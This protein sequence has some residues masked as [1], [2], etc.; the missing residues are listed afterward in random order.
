[1]SLAILLAALA[2]ASLLAGVNAQAAAQIRYVAPGGTCGS[3]TLCYSTI[4]AA[5]DAAQ[6]GD[7]IRVAAGTYSG[8]N[9]QGGWKQ[10]VYIDKS[11][12]IRGGFTTSNWTT[13]NPEANVTE[14]NAMTLGRVMYISGAQTAVTLEGLQLTYG[15]SSGLGGHSPTIFENYDAGGGVYIYE[16]SVN[17]DQCV[18]GH[19]FS[20]S[21][22]YG[23][24]LYLRAGSLEMTGSTVESNEAGSG[25]GLYL[26][27]AQSQIGSNTTLSA[28]RGSAIRAEKGNLTLQK[29]CVESNE[30]GGVS[31][32]KNPV[33]IENNIISDTI[34]GT[35]LSV[36]GGGQVSHNLIQGNDHAGL[37]IADGD[38]TIVGNEI[39]YN[40]GKFT[41]QDPGVLI[42]PV[43]GGDVT[44]RD[45][46]IHHNTNTY[47]ACEGAGVYIDTGPD[48][49]VTLANNLIEDNFAGEDAALPSHGYGGGVYLRGDNILLDGNI[50]RNNTAFGF[51]WAVTQFWGGYGGGVYINDS[52]TLQNNIIAGNTIMAPDSTH[53]HAPGIYVNGGSP[54]L[55]HNTLAN[56][57]GGDGVGLYVIQ[58]SFTEER[59][60]V[61]MFNSI[62]VSHTVGIYAPGEVAENIVIADGILWSSNGVDTSGTGTFFLSHETSGDPAFVDPAGGDYHILDSSAAIDQG[63]DT[64]VTSDIDGEPRFAGEVDLGADEYWVPGSFNYLFLPLVITD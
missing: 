11:L 38:F 28:N 15:D 22:G 4:Q 7:E 47:S 16:A 40:R 37:S 17:F 6:A 2:V 1:M 55:I 31:A 18:I 21:N 62:V 3:K 32:F 56:N 8:I 36:N 29:S 64:S 44:L 45:N 52:P 53:F 43:W 27:E 50:I 41:L 54:E 46:H 25:G 34:D 39:A 63:V 19:N 57:S 48:G 26:Y 59:A 12:T 33:V 23:G 14:I 20:P 61:Q 35:G 51:I 10:V 13:P 49:L 5:V 60:Q 42:Q 58:D 9:T 30:D 24:G